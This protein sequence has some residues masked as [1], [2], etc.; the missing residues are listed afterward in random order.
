[1]NF[2]K[3]LRTPAAYEDTAL[4]PFFPALKE[5]VSDKN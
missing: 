2:A 1:M 5:E 3:C 4:S